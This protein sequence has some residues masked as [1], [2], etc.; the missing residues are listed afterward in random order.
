[1]I[2]AAFTK[3][4]DLFCKFEVSG[5]ADFADFGDDIVCAGVS[6]AVQMCANGITEVVGYPAKVVCEENLIS[7]EL[8]QNE[9]N[10]FCEV[11]MASLFLQLSVL[12]QSY[13]DSINL[14]FRRC[15]D[16]C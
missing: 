1:M 16:Q 7:V 3:H 10:E 14:Y 2:K 6:S 15:D 13:K 11:L 12:S 4:N 9:P 8:M 5:H